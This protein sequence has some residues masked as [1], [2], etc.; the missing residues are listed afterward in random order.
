MKHSIK[1]TAIL[2]AMFLAAQLIGLFVVHQYSP[3]GTTL[4]YGM[5]PPKEIE[6]QSP[7]ELVLSFAI[8]FAIV[9]AI[10][11]LFT[12]YKFD[13]IL[14]AWFFI[15]ITLAIGTTLNSIF[16]AFAKTSLLAL[17]VALPL[18]YYKVFKRNII[19]HNIT[20]LLIYPGIAAIFVIMLISWTTKPILAVCLILIA[21]SIYDM[22]AVW[23]SGFMQKMAQYQIQKLRIFAGFFVPYSGTKLR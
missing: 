2:L 9:I 18:A 17:F 1:I 13:K 11:I 12:K 15:V 20:E 4:P 7:W 6:P 23:H 8:S 5:Q 22:Y 19:L 21:I 3:D 10:M 14:R 16:Q